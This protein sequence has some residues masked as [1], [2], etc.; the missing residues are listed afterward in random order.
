MDHQ[1]EIDRCQA[2]IARAAERMMNGDGYAVMGWVDWQ[3]EL[4]IILIERDCELRAQ[5]SPHVEA[6]HA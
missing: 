3:A 6:T 2:E 4:E 5:V 1:K